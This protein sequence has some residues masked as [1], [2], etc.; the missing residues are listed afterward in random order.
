MTLGMS[1]CRVL[2]GECFLCARY[3]CR[4]GR[5][6]LGMTFS[7]RTPA[8]QASRLITKRITYHNLQDLSPTTLRHQ[9]AQQL[10]GEEG[11]T[12]KA[13]MTL[14]WKPR[15]QSGLE[16]LMCAIFARHRIGWLGHLHGTVRLFPS[17]PQVSPPPPQA[18]PPPLRVCRGLAVNF[19][20]SFFQVN[21]LNS[22]KATFSANAFQQASKSFPGRFQIVS[23][24]FPDAGCTGMGCAER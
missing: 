7:G 24:R 6:R 23:K 22:P 20:K 14:T 18:P 8:Q 16:R 13:L 9:P 15:P 3:P 12:E 1:Y 10:P 17:D 4:P 11:T 2:G 5:A 19:L 21:S